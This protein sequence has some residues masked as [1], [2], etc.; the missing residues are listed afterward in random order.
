MRRQKTRLWSIREQTPRF[1]MRKIRLQNWQSVNCWKT[2]N[3]SIVTKLTIS[4]LLQ[5][6]QSANGCKTDNQSIVG[7][8]TINQRKDK[9][10][11]NLSIWRSFRKQRIKICKLCNHSNW[12]DC[13]C[14]CKI[15]KLT[16]WAYTLS[17]QT[18]VEYSKCF[19]FSTF[20]SPALLER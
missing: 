13:F 18:K 4:K 15:A 3:Q 19:I 2:D 7:R 17:L 12:G 11:T 10:I 6:G 20:L 5:N 14:F 8:L 9:S 1:R 16:I